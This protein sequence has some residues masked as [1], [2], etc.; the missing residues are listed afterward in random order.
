M[1]SRRKNVVL[2]PFRLFWGYFINGNAMKV[3]EVTKYIFQWDFYLKQYIPQLV[4]DL[5]Y[6]SLSL[7]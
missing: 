1:E 5:I 7:I 3:K 4:V 6:P 2:D